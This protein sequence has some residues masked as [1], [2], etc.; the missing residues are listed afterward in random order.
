MV[1]HAAAAAA[2]PG[3]GR[4]TDVQG[5]AQSVGDSE[6]DPVSHPAVCGTDGSSALRDSLDGAESEMD[7]SPSSVP[8][9]QTVRTNR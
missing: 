6:S 7:Y 9:H 4:V 1:T 5:G 8:R 2:A 3:R